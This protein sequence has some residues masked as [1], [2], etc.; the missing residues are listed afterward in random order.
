MTI[1]NQD[2]EIHRGDSALLE[3]SLTDAN[4]DPYVPQAGDSVIYR[5]AAN[6]HIRQEDCL[7]EKD[8]DNG[9]SVVNGIVAV[10]LSPID[11]NIRPRSYYHELKVI[12]G[13][14]VATAMIGNFEIRHALVSSEIS[15][16][17]SGMSFAVISLAGSVRV[18]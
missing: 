3:I 5:V 10:A 9:I 18:I 2:V 14:D 6:S 15:Q 12:D 7:I 4:G 17:G 11:T 1:A 13:P 16:V 8:L